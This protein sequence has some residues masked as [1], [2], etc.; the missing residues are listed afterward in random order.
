MVPWVKALVTKPDDS[1]VM[2]KTHLVER[3]SQ[4]TNVLSHTHM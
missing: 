2:P 1:D 4:L 3:M